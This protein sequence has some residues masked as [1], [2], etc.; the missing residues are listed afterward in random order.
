[1]TLSKNNDKIMT[2]ALTKFDK[3]WKNSLASHKS[4]RTRHSATTIISTASSSAFRKYHLLYTFLSVWHLSLLRECAH[5]KRFQFTRERKM[6]K[7]RGKERQKKMS[8][9]AERDVCKQASSVLIRNFSVTLNCGDF[10]VAK[11]KHSWLF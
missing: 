3:G 1:M 10:S 2:K 8:F 9:G 5:I 7:R 11:K 4:C 6:K